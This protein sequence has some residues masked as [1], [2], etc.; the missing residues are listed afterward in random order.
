[1]AWALAVVIL[2][3]RLSVLYRVMQGSCKG[4]GGVSYWSFQGHASPGVMQGSGR[5]LQG[6]RTGASSDMPALG[7]YMRQTGVR[8]ES[9]RGV[10]RVMV[11]Q[12]HASSDIA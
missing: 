9:C 1:M 2:L 4:H 3:Y 6:S 12:G 5:G 8:E 11:I 10:T 7:S